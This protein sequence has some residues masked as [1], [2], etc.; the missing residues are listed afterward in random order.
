M[1]KRS[2]LIGLAIA[3]SSFI[4]GYATNSFLTEKKPVN[5]RKVIGVG[6]IFFKSS[7]PKALKEWYS[8]HL[9]LNIDE[10]GTNF[11]TRHSLDSTKFAFLQWSPFK[12]NTKYFEP[13]KKDWMINYRVLNLE[14][15]A[16]DLKKSGVTIVDT[17]STYD[18]GKFLHIMDLEGNKIE[19]WEA[20]DDVYHK[21]TGGVTR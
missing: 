16:K 21:Y 19:L 9:G 3:L 11:E 5:E 20:N 7:N 17:I 18:Y 10:Y 14:K 8:T 13:S 1:Y 4:V 6:G 2:L 15:L 12:D